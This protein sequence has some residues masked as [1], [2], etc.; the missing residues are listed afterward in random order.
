MFLGMLLAKFSKLPK[1]N[2]F[3]IFS[4]LAKKGRYVFIYNVITMLIKLGA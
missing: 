4:V 3:H 1:L 2:K